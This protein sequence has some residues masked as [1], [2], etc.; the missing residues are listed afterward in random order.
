MYI[1][2]SDNY[3]NSVENLNSDKFVKVPIEVLE[4]L[5]DF[6]NW[7]KF[8]SNRYYIEE[9]SYP[10]VEEIKKNTKFNSDPWD[11]FSG[12]HFGY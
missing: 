4:G 3:K 12:T 1:K 6:N 11:N 8:I 2:I 9:T 7:K 10:I 5:Q